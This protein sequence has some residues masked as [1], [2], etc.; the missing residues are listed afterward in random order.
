MK[1]EIANPYIFTVLS[2]F[3]TKIATPFVLPLQVFRM[4]KIKCCLL[5]WKKSSENERDTA[6]AGVS[7]RDAGSEFLCFP[8]F[9][10]L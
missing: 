1:A 2:F 8:A 5:L 3:A 9:P 10:P 6:M 7:I 4:F